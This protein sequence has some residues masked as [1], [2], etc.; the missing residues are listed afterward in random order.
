MYHNKRDKKNKDGSIR[1]YRYYHC[2]GLKGMKPCPRA[3]FRADGPDGVEVLVESIFRSRIAG[4]ELHRRKYVAGENHTAE[5]ESVERRIKRLRDD[6]E[7]GLYDGEKDEAEYADT[8][9]WL[10]S[11]RKRL[12]ALPVRQAEYVDEP[13]GETFGQVW[14]RLDSEGRRRLMIEAG[15]RF[16]IGYHDDAMQPSLFPDVEP[17]RADGPILTIHMPPELEKRA[18]E[19][20]A[21]HDA[22]T[23]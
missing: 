8:M 21:R 18:Q 2:N 3:S 11:E 22:A 15:V 5:L 16:E 17:Q 10:I 23:Q 12:A 7:S 19:W 6:R 20:A 4:V 1:H 13:T 14:D 9:R